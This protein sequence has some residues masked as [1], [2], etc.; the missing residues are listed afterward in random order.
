[1]R[2]NK[3]FLLLL[4]LGKP[5]WSQTI[6]TPFYK[7]ARTGD[8]V[9]MDVSISEPLDFINIY[10]KTGVTS[11][12]SLVGIITVTPSVSTYTWSYKMPGGTTAQYR[13]WAVTKKG[14]ELLDESNGVRVKR[15]K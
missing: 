14:S 12:P 4:L 13:F 6:T 10:R 8:V 11:T 3:L 15:V 2:F 5:A 1:M 9:E 7:E